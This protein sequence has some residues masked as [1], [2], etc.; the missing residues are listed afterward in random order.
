MAASPTRTF[1]AA[2]RVA[3]DS[4]A[5]MAAKSSVA[6]SVS[7]TARRLKIST[8][9]L[10]LWPDRTCRWKKSCCKWALRR[11]R[12]CWLPRTSATPRFNRVNQ[13]R[14]H[15]LG[16]ASP[17]DSLAREAPAEANSLQRLSFL[18]WHKLMRSGET[19]SQMSNS[20]MRG[21]ARNIS[22]A[23]LPRVSA[24]PRLLS[25]KYTSQLPSSMANE[26]RMAADASRKFR[27]SPARWL[28]LILPPTENS[29]SS[30]TFRTVLRTCR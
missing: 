4:P 7:A 23:L 30:P 14:H 1:L 22:P 29:F 16:A 28:L 12:C 21:C 27:C 18:E 9:Q 2:S 17:R 3:S 11:P 19:L 15:L 24:S 13:S 26:Q 25:R 20:T 6:R 5:A 8:A 10:R